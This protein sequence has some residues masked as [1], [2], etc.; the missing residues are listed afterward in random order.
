MLVLLTGTAFSCD[1]NSDI[2]NKLKQAE[3]TMFSAPDSALDILEEIHFKELSRMSP[4]QKAD[5]SILL[6]KVKLRLDKSF[7]TDESFDPAVRYLESISDTV[8]LLDIY[9]LAAIK[10]RWERQQDSAV[11]YM[12][13]AIDLVPDS[14]NHIKSSLFIKLSNIYA[15]YTLKKDYQKALLYAKLALSTANSSYDKARALHD[16]GLFYSYINKNDSALIY[17]E[18]ALNETDTANPEYNTYALNYASLTNADL[19]KSVEFLNHIEGRHL[20]KLITLGYLYLNQSKL[21]SALQYLN[22]AKILYQEKPNSYSINTYNSLRHLEQSIGLLKTGVVSLDEGTMT[23]DSISEINDIQQKI[24]N[25]QHDYNVWLQIQLLESKAQ[26]QFIWIVSLSILLLLTVC[27]GV[28]VWHTKRNYLMLKHQLD[29]IK[30][31]QIMSEAEESEKALKTN[32]LIKKRLDLCIEQFRASGLQIEIDKTEL[33]Y[34][35]EDSYPSLK[36]RENIQKRLIGYFADFIVDI[37]MTG[38]KLNMEDIIT[39][40]MTCLKESNMA[41]AACLGVTDTAIRTRKTRLRAKLT[42]EMIDL[43]NL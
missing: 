13:K 7:V 12:M 27:F 1:R 25:E 40:I 42:S 33:K 24:A 38:V 18:K 36:Q 35:N 32:D 28:Y 22:E 4:N 43:L 19:W 31:E 41:I 16:I 39:C 6:S 3:A 23:N 9:Q 5:L 15:Y 26:R 37:K 17:M 20:G 29:K 34:R 8:R 30:I 14:S 2:D 11:Y 10:K 21:D